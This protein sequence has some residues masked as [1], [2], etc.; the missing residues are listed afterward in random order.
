[1]TL[2]AAG[3]R[4]DGDDRAPAECIGQTYVESFL[5]LLLA[6]LGADVTVREVVHSV[7]FNDLFAA[8]TGFGELAVG[9]QSPIV[10]GVFSSERALHQAAILE[11]AKDSTCDLAR[12]FRRGGN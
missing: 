4:M 11:S 3:A 6:G 10:E 8:G 9:L 5:P 1:M 12:R 2:G 7:D